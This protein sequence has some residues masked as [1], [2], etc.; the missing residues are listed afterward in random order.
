MLLKHVIIHIFKAYLWHFCNP[1]IILFS[2]AGFAVLS[3][4]IFHP[5][6]RFHMT[7]ASQGR[8]SHTPS[9]FACNKARNVRHWWIILG[10]VDTKRKKYT[11]RNYWG[12]KVD[13][14]TPRRV[15][16]HEKMK[17]CASFDYNFISDGALSKLIFIINW[18]HSFIQALKL[19]KL[20]RITEFSLLASQYLSGLKEL[21]L[22]RFKGLFGSL[23]FSCGALRHINPSTR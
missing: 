7:A 12:G 9:R 18:L 5:S 16:G 11:N 8:R 19:I 3:A 17:N 4:K 14:L 2:C 1:L 22:N 10:S 23:S 21:K 13:G 15:I 6:L 20:E